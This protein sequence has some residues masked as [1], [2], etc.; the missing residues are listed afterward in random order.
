MPWFGIS[1]AH[2]TP[3]I[4]R[5]GWL[6][7]LRFVA[8]FL[9]IIYH[10]QWAGPVPLARFSPIFDHG[11]LLTD[12][13]LIDSGYVL[14]R[15]YGE[16]VLATGLSPV[17]FLKIRAAR[18]VPA[19]LLVLSGLIAIV[20]AAGMAGFSPRHGAWFDW[21]Q[22]PAQFFLVQ[23]YGVPGGVGWN[24]PSWSLSALLGCYVAFPFLLRGLAR[25][26]AWT[27]LTLGIGVYGAANLLSWKLYGQG[28][29]GLPLKFGFVR[30]LPLFF[31]GMALARLSQ[32]VYLPRRVAATLGGGAVLGLVALQCT[33]SAGLA[34][35]SLICVIILAAGAMPPRRR[36]WLVEKAA[37]VS[38]S[39]FITNEVVRVAWF[40]IANVVIGR[41]HLGIGLQWALW[42]GGVCAA[43]TAAI[44]FHIL[45]DMPTQR[46]IK[47]RLRGS[48][49][50][51]AHVPSKLSPAAGS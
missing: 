45:V 36:S 3:P 34:S 29:Y 15:V 22:L 14:A 8:A 27:V 21:G 44:A 5:G 47:A 50:V 31:V 9:I 16:R 38:F 26:K 32:M 18:V 4:Q 40:G 49:T 23:A 28:V 2:E 43:M 20:L 24:A 12:F 1:A 25:L 37:L 6:D 42:A 35:L 39:M 10:Y 48:G 11:Y 7:V 13:F 51:R 30:A 46:W 19:H 41:L 33:G 17:S